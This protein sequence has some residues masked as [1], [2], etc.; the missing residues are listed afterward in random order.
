[1]TFC[2]LP[3]E[4]FAD[5]VEDRRR[6]H[7]ELLDL[8]LGGAERSP[9]RL[10]LS[11]LEKGAW[12]YALRTRF[13]AT[14]KPGISPPRGDPRAR[15]RRRLGKTRRGSRRTRRPPIRISPDSIGRS[16]V[17]ASTSSVWPFPCTPAMATISPACTTRSTSVD[18]D[19][20][21]G[22][23]ARRGPSISSTASPGSAG[24]LSTTSSTGAPDHHRRQLLE[25]ALGGPRRADHLAPAQDRDPV[26]DLQD[27]VQLVGDEDDG[28]AGRRERAHD[29]RT[30]P[31]SSC[32]VRT[33][34]GS[35]RIRIRDSR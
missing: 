22:R 11:P 34:V 25:R 29:R 30:A 1:M 3:P 35:S 19:A 16:P 17:I 10:S 5:V 9:R 32:G 18:G 6:P 8:R 26:G 20:G 12:Q 15:G 4:R 2:W 21:R 33:A 27:L 7:V 24:G 14:V 31:R 23:R 13:S 28:R